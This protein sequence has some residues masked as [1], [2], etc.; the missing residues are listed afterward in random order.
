VRVLKAADAKVEDLAFSPDGRAIAAGTLYSGIFLWDLEVFPPSEVKVPS[1]M[2]YKKGGLFFSLDGS[3]LTWLVSG[4]FRRTYDRDTRRV[5]TSNP[6]ASTMETLEILQTP[7]GAHG[8][9]RHELPNY[10]L[11]C[12][13]F[14]DDMPVQTGN[15]SI[16]DRHVENLTLSVDGRLFAML[17]RPALGEGWTNNPRKVEVRDATSPTLPLRGTGEYPYKYGDKKGGRLLFSPDAQ[18]LVGFNNMTLLVWRIAENGDLGTPRLIRNTTRKQF[19]ALVFHPSGRY[20]YVTSNGGDAN[21]ATVHV[22]DTLTWTRV[23]QFV[24]H[25]GNMKAVAVSPD[26][27]LAA[28]GGDRGD[29]V[30]WD[31]D[32]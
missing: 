31:V 12:W 11:L 15:L 2:D 17:T 18:Q 7:D 16:A 10:R 5:S 20:L 1:Q 24:W 4:P 13:R 22:F 23:E 3:S 25:L 27:M 9:T 6:F 21:D 19:T 14:V 28:A 8:I 32:Q 26:G 30:I 29:I